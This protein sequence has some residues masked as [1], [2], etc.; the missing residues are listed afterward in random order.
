MHC[1]IYRA[2]EAGPQRSLLA[3]VES[4]AKSVG[5]PDL[6]WLKFGD[7]Y[8]AY[9]SAGPL[10]GAPMR[11]AGLTLETEHSLEH[12]RSE[13]LCLVIQKGRRFQ[14]LHPNV[15]IVFNRGRHL[16]VSLTGPATELIGTSVA[17][18]YT[19]SAVS[20]GEVV[21]DVCPRPSPRPPTVS[22]IQAIVDRMSRVGLRA[23]TT[24]LGSYLTRNSLTRL[25]REAA[26]WAAGNLLTMRYEVTV[27]AFTVPR[28]SRSPPGRSLNVVAERRGALPEGR[29]LILVVAHLDSVNWDAPAEQHT[30]APAPGA[31]DNAS[32]SAGLLAMA[33]IF[34]DAEMDHDLRFVL[35]G[36]EEQGL[37]GSK[38]YVQ[39]L[40]I[41]D[42]T[43][44]LVTINMDMIAKVRRRP[45]AVLLEGAPVSK[46]FIEAMCD[47]A[48]RYTNL[49]V[50]TSLNP[51][52][53]DH[54]SFLE[55]GIPAVLTIEGSDQ[56]EDTAADTLDLLDFDLALEIL[57]MNSAFV[58]EQL[59]VRGTGRSHPRAATP[60]TV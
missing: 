2:T 51:Y 29:R 60:T 30:S 25:F 57:R 7:R 45:Y 6:R 17:S 14:D 58:A 39:R 37:F 10:D 13:S 20:G 15:P 36:A 5:S 42:R 47:A 46:S 26:D 12:V 38:H 53:S 41:H 55:K 3:N 24:T 1:A 23:D 18:G 8:F 35:F 43:R 56:P 4:V 40:S 28:T 16:L 22:A 31:D 19:V 33:R 27:D 52:A 59:G 32:S 49:E 54:V 34:K 50:L 44:I 11:A 21:F 9:S 48:H